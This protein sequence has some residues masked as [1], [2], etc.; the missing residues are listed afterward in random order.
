VHTDSTLDAHQDRIKNQGRA[1]RYQ[2]GYD[3]SQTEKQNW[4][5]LLNNGELDDCEGTMYINALGQIIDGC[6]FSY[7]TQR[8]H[9]LGSVL[10]DDL[11]EII[12]KHGHNANEGVKDEAS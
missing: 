2:L 7:V 1:A 9:T 5:Y 11:A 4:R 10:T 8:K 6:D 3:Q 12:L